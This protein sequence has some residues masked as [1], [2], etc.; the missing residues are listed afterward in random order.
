M[1][2]Q[3][4]EERYMAYMRVLFV[5][6]SVV[7]SMLAEPSPDFVFCHRYDELG[8]PESASRIGDFIAPNK[9][10]AGMVSDSFVKS[11]EAR[12]GLNESL[13]FYGAEHLA[14]HLQNILDGIDSM[15]CQ[16]D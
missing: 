2:K 14:A 8:D 13:P 12:K 5:T 16:R 4:R 6:A 1:E 3:T 7:R 10:V 11:A 9:Y 15:H